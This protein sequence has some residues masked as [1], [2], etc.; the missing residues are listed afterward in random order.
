RFSAVVAVRLL[1]HLAALLTELPSAAPALL[2]PLTAVER[3]QVL[4]EWNDTAVDFPRERTLPE[5]FAEVTRR[6]PEAVAVELDGVRWTYGELDARTDR[7]AARLRR[8][9]V[10]ADGEEIRV[11]L[12]AEETPALVE[13]MLGILKAG[14]V[15]VPL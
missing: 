5:L 7:L 13:G 3:H 14:G 9:G 4:W 8:L 10:G 11:G 12:A 15:Y 2:T 1:A 6:Q